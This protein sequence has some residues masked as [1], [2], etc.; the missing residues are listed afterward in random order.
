VETASTAA[1]AAAVAA[2]ELDAAA[3]AAVAGRRYGLVALASDIGERRDAVTRFVRLGLLDAAPARTGNDRT[4][5]VLTVAHTPGSLGAVLT[6]FAVRGINLTRLES[7]PIRETLGEYVFLVDADGHI[8]DQAMA[9]T[10]TALVRRRELKRFLGSYP[11]ALGTAVSVP[12]FAEDGAYL[13]AQRAV[14][15]IGRTGRDG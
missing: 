12:E 2:G 15:S 7:R 4:S 13:E 3:C 10:L 1:A 6:E 11:R 5:L 8:A 9:D 14:E